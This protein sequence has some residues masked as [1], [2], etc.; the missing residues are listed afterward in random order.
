MISP[1]TMHEAGRRRRSR[2]RR[3]R[4]G[5]SREDRVEDRVRDLVAHLVGVAFGHRFGRE[6]VVRRRRRCWSSGLL[7]QG[8]PKGSTHSPRPRSTS[9]SGCHAT[10]GWRFRPGAAPSDG[11]RPRPTLVA[12]PQPRLR[13]RRRLSRAPHRTVLLGHRAMDE[14]RRA[15]WSRVSDHRMVPLWSRAILMDVR[16]AAGERER[17]PSFLESGDRWT[18]AGWRRIVTIVTYA[19]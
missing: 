3:G 6:Q 16:E 5:R 12:W 8:R 7:V 19:A 15:S 9:K 1:R 14:G 10:F 13:Y 11:R 18:E 4:A 2:R 17:L